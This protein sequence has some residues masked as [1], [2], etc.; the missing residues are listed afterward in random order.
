MWWARKRART[1]WVQ[2]VQ[3]LTTLATRSN[4][5]K[6]AKN[7]TQWW[8]SKVLF[9]IAV[10]TNQAQIHPYRPIRSRATVWWATKALSTESSLKVDWITSP[11][12]RAIRWH[13][14]RKWRPNN[15][16]NHLRTKT[17]RKAQTNWTCRSRRHFRGTE[18]YW[19]QVCDSLLF[20]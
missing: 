14:V 12:T 1:Q 7:S 3:I 2:L 9:L 11:R 19:Q 20:W 6:P 16:F 17:T 4:F 5:N 8:K 15:N 10:W 13:K 18:Q